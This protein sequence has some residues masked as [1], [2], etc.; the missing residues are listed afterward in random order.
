MRMAASTLAPANRLE[1]RRYLPLCSALAVSTASTAYSAI[2]PC[3]GFPVQRSWGSAHPPG[4]PASRGPLRY[5]TDLPLLNLMSRPCLRSHFRLHRTIGPSGVCSSRRLSS[6]AFG[7]PPARTRLP[8]GLLLVGPRSI[9]A[10]RSPKG[11]RPDSAARAS[12]PASR[13]TTEVVTRSRPS[14]RRAARRRLPSPP[15]GEDSCGARCGLQCGPMR[16]VPSRVPNCE[17]ASRPAR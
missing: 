13:T 14:P 3:S 11:A 1:P 4:I 9:R 7:F 2:H 15:E 17:R 12:S 5:R 16:S 10:P 8:P 6:L